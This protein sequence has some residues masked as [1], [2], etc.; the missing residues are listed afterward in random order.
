[1]Y[2]ILNILFGI[3]FITDN[4]AFRK[5]SIESNGVPLSMQQTA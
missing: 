2:S 1:M 4:I 5:S 3:C